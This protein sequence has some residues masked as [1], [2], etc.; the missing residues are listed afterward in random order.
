[1]EFAAG[2]WL[3]EGHLGRVMRALSRF[4]PE[5]VVK[6]WV[7]R[8][9]M[10]EARYVT[11]VEFL[12]LLANSIERPKALSVLPSSSKPIQRINGLFPLHSLSPERLSP[13]RWA[14]HIANTAVRTFPPT[15]IL[16]GD[17]P[18]LR[19]ARKTQH[20]AA[21]SLDHTLD[22]IMRTPK[23]QGEIKRTLK[24]QLRRV[25]QAKASRSP[26]LRL[27]ALK[28]DQE[29]P[30]LSH[31]RATADYQSRYAQEEKRLS[32]VLHSPKALRRS[33]EWTSYSLK[34]SVA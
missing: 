11:P 25:T 2:V 24:L 7:Q 22:A 33:Q 3:G 14:Q 26:R 28:E 19:T 13:D 1:M 34:D 4:I 6:L 30:L 20:R 16:E 8:Y 12:Y 29:S 15:F 10:H 9:A 23:L 17:S 18:S 32:T 21:A 31:I 5:E 27:C